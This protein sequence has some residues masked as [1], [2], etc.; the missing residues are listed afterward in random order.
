MTTAAIVIIIRR[1]PNTPASAPYDPETDTIAQTGDWTQP[2]NLKTA[3][4][5]IAAEQQ[6]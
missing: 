4:D 3:S 6:I 2:V 1:P 5:T